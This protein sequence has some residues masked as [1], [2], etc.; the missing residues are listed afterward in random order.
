LRFGKEKDPNDPDYVFKKL[1]I[2]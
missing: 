1:K 2:D